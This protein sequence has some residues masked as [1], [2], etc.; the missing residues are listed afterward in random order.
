LTYLP[1]TLEDDAVI[2]DQEFAK[3]QEESRRKH[4]L[5]I[6]EQPGESLNETLA[7]RD[8]REHHPDAIELTTINDSPSPDLKDP[9]SLRSSSPP[10]R[11]T[12]FQDIAD[13]IEDLSIEERDVLVARAFQHP[14]VRAK[15]PVIWIPRDRLGV[16]DDEIR[17]T[18]KLTDKVW[19]SNEY[20]ALDGDGKVVFRK[21]PP[22]MDYMATVEL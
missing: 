2:A 12:I 21:P 20:A 6:D 18:R 19:I 16:S 17:R 4:Q 22:D 5:T 1:I 3:A 10:E 15:R 13:E 14:A 8:R 7:R 11:P 9:E